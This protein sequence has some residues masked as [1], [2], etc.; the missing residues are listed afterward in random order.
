LEKNPVIAQLQTMKSRMDSI[1]MENFGMDKNPE[2]D[3][4]KEKEEWLPLVDII[5]KD[6]EWLLM[7]DLPGVDEEDLTV[8]ILENMIK[9]TGSRKTMQPSHEYKP[10][11]EERPHGAFS[12][13]F[14]LPHN[15]GREEVAARLNKGVLTIAI[16]KGE[17]FATPHKV[18]VVPE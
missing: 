16:P 8:E 4:T 3:E 18:S 14:R 12:R 6:S 11:Y 15:A 5:E 1:F 10:V 2:H 17:R 7:A 9:I 13:T